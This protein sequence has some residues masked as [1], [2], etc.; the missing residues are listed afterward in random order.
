MLNDLI[1]M[2]AF[3]PEFL[4]RLDIKAPVRIPKSFGSD[5]DR[6]YHIPCIE[7]PLELED[8]MDYESKIDRGSDNIGRLLAEGERAAATFLEARKSAVAASA[9][10]EGETAG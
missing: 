3:R 5:A 6:P 2:D 4:S 8:L 9:L 7:M 1:L 10:Q